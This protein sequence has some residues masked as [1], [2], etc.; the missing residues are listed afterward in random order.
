MNILELV[1]LSFLLDE[2]VVKNEKEDDE[3]EI[4]DDENEDHPLCSEKLSQ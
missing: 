4:E 3:N 2:Y 1:G